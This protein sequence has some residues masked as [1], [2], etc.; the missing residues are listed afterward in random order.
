MKIQTIPRIHK[1]A[2][3]LHGQQVEQETYRLPNYWSLHFYEYSG[4]IDCG[5]QRYQLKPGACSIVPADIPITFYYQGLSK[6]LYCHFQ[7]QTKPHISEF[8]FIQADTRLPQLKNLL[9]GAHSL[10]RTA[11]QRANLRL[12]DVLLGLQDI[13]TYPDN[14]LKH[15]RILETATEIVQQEMTSPLTIQELARRCQLSHNQFT[16]TIKQQTGDTPAIWLRKLRTERAKELL[17]YSNLPIKVIATEVGYP[18]LQHFNK[19]IRQHLGVSPR[20]FRQNQS[21]LTIAL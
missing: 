20:R 10:L 6:H 14:H 11:P 12:W 17:S 19:V 1:L 15:E 7:L 5:T 13:V 2:W 4:W 21:R 16:R 8:N 9:A 18:D 3:A